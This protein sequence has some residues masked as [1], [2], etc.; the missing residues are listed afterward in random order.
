MT[1]TYS[2]WE[3]KS[4]E[5]MHLYRL[6]IFF[7][8]SSFWGCKT[9]SNLPSKYEIEP[10]LLHLASVDQPDSIGFN[11]VSSIHKLIYPLIQNG[12][13]ALWKTSKKKE[14]VNKSQ[15][16]KIEES[17]DTRFV[18]SNDLFIHEYWQLIGK[19]FDFL[20]LG[21]SF[22]GKTSIG[23][24]VSYGFVDAADVIGILKS[25]KIPTTH[26]GPSNMS[27]WNAIHSKQFNF[28]VVQFGNND[29]KSNPELSVLLKNQACYSRSINRNFYVPEKSRRVIY[30]IISPNINSNLENKKIYTET[31]S[32]IN[33]NKQ[34]ILNITKKS[35]EP[36]D[37]IKPWSINSIRVIEKWSNYKNIPLQELEYLLL[38]ING[39][40]YKL[41][42]QEIEEVGLSINLQGISEYLSEKNFDFIIEKV[43]SES[44]PPQKSE[45]MYTKLLKN[46]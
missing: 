23:E 21:F 30:K 45:S 38:E 9:Q 39:K 19:E 1:Y 4:Q 25:I 24:P 2:S 33:D 22:V 3:W 13:I 43:N 34:V 15:F 28:N 7:V 31:E 29:F 17:Y 37:I 42:K 46:I 12:D 6:L 14:L 8:I 20:V 11:L 40:N 27:Y 41:N 10:V 32:G 5:R 44:I 16:L 35:V 18:N 26:Q 36:Q